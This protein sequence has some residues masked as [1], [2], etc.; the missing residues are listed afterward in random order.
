MKTV[1][2]AAAIIADDIR[3]PKTVFAAARGY[4]EYKGLWEFPGGKLEEGE[5]PKEAL[6]R[7]IREEL[8]VEIEPFEWFDTVEY[9]YPD[10]HLSMDCYWSVIWDGEPVLKEASEA[11]WFTAGELKDLEWLP[12][13]SQLID[14]IAAKLSGEE[15]EECLNDQDLFSGAQC[16]CMDPF[17]PNSPYQGSICDSLGFIMYMSRD[18]IRQ[19][20]PEALK[21]LTDMLDAGVFPDDMAEELKAKIY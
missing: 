3:E 16:G 4:G 12:A 5:S 15:P 19:M 17:D 9:D 14:R 11:G 7:E 10:F 18:E 6:I 8:A 1:R 13:D 21:E 20:P 2:V